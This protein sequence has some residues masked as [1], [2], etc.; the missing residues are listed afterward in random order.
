MTEGESVPA[1]EIDV[2]GEDCLLALVTANK[3]QWEWTE[4]AASDVGAW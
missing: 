4:G 2:S 1:E 3:P